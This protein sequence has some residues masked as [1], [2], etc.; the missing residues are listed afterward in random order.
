[1]AQQAH[2]EQYNFVTDGGFTNLTTNYGTNY[3]SNGGQMGNNVDVVGWSNTAA[4]NSFDKTNNQGGTNSIG[5]NFLFTTN[6]VNNTNPVYGNGGFYN[7]AATS[8]LSLWNNKN[9]GST[10]NFTNPPGNG[11]FIAADGGFQTAAITQTITGLTT[12]NYYQLTF[13]Y[14]AAQQTDQL[15]NTTESW[16]VSMTGT[17][18]NNF[19]TNTPTLSNRPAGFTGW[20]L[21]TINFKASSSTE[22]LSFLAAGTPTGGPPF[23]LLADVSIVAVP[24][25]SSVITAALLLL[26]LCAAPLLK[27]LKE[28]EGETLGSSEGAASGD[29]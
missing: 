27:S 7:G 22:V 15:T 23:S 14:A 9:G 20:D 5:Y 8:P 13:Y 11:N 3:N 26:I 6:M 28:K 19:T 10:D 2:A 16:Q 4:T 24:E 17:N 18:G 12:N 29:P 21:E 25:A 1:M